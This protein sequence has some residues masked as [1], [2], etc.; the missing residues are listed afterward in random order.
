MRAVEV[1]VACSPAAEA[2]VCN[3]AVVV[4]AAFNLEAVLSLEEGPGRRVPS[5]TITRGKLAVSAVEEHCLDLEGAA[6]FLL[7]VAGNREV[8]ASN[9]AAE[10]NRAAAVCNPAAAAEA[11]R[12]A[13]RR[14]PSRSS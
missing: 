4:E 6:S 1:A 8:V 2:V 7:A 9:Q 10:Y 11:P 14:F 5:P 3:R 13:D 12:P